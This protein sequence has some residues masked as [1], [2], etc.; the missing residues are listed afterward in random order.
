MDPLPAGAQGSRY[1][2]WQYGSSTHHVVPHT[3]TWT[4]ARESTCTVQHRWGVD[5]MACHAAYCQ[6]L[7][8]VRHVHHRDVHEEP[9]TWTC[10]PYGTVGCGGSSSQLK[11]GP[12]ISFQGVLQEYGFE[13]RG[14]TT[15]TCVARRA[16]Q[17]PPLGTV[18][19]GSVA[20]W[21]HAFQSWGLGEQMQLGFGNSLHSKTL[22][23]GEVVRGGG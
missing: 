8:T 6:P 2:Q 3:T 23:F 10:V 9:V 17:A 18:R 19:I 11:Q 7:R 13:S 14:A 16:V 15:A 22:K 12:R 4:A 21:Q 5:R 20:T 1:G